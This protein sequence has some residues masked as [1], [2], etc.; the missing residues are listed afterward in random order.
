M[1]YNLP[2][3]VRTPV[4][5]GVN[6]DAESIAAIAEFIVGF[7]NLAGYELMPFHRLGE[8]KFRSLGMIYQAAGLEEPTRKTMEILASAARNAGIEIVLIA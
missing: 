7:P 5:P 6:D 1:V 3:L 4:I 2:V 8:E